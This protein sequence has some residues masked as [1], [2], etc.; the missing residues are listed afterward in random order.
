MA[1]RI[2]SVIGVL[3]VAY[4]A[5]AF[6]QIFERVEEKTDL[7]W[8]AKAKKN[9]YLAVQQLT[10]NDGHSLQVFDSLQKLD[11]LEQY[12]FIYL[13]DSQLLLS[14]S[15]LELLM[16]WVRE[17]GH[18]MV[19]ATENADTYAD[20]LLERLSIS[21]DD[22]SYSDD[23][24]DDESDEGEA[25]S[26][27]AEDDSDESKEDPKEV[28]QKV[29]DELRRYNE[30]LQ[31]EKPKKDDNHALP[32]VTDSIKLYDSNIDEGDVTNLYFGD[33]QFPIAAELNV[34]SQIYHPAMDDEDWAEEGQRVIYW[35]GTGRGAHFLQI[36]LGRGL[37]SITTDSRLFDSHNIGHFDHALLWETLSGDRSAIIYGSNMPSLWRIIWRAMPELTIALLALLLFKIWQVAGHFGPQRA[38]VVLAR[39]SFNEHLHASAGFLWRYRWQAKL[40]APL[41]EEIKTLASAKITGFHSATV[42]RQIELLAE[43]SQ[44]NASLVREAL[45]S[46]KHLSEDGFTKL[47]QVLQEMRKSL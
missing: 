9:P 21:I 36:E 46:E 43:H 33:N 2:L 42:D 6:F 22:A 17:G 15:R 26:S 1:S 14:E 4:L 30:N 37:F 38:E 28:A 45:F 31:K 47:V 18:L 39:R 5:Y 40:L 25:D 32:S 27:D 7:G 24:F 34:Y 35:E 10:E 41:R 16:T 8:R 29:A 20:M 12:D 11:A 44:L 13:A 23:E 3:F 19:S